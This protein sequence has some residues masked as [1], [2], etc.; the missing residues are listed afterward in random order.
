M[1]EKTEQTTEDQNEAD[2]IKEKST[3]SQEEA[4][5]V[6]WFAKYKQGH[7]TYLI[8]VR[9]LDLPIRLREYRKHF[10]QVSSDNPFHASRL[11]CYGKRHCS[12]C[13]YNEIISRVASF[14][15]NNPKLF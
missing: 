14:P 13:V 12:V 9:E 15:M 6:D 7:D 10:K 2:V 11:D 4:W 1:E 3:S 5:L 8:P